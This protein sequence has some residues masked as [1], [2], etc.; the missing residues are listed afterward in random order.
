MAAEEGVI[1]PFMT[2]LAHRGL[3]YVPEVSGLSACST[4]L[5]RDHRS[6]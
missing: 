1:Q 3:C 4:V 5:A 2:Y 6:H